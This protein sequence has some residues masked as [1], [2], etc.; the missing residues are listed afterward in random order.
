MT[1]R[2]R[3]ADVFRAGWDEYNR[4]NRVAPHQSKAV[5]HILSCRTARLGGHMYRCDKCAS[6]LPVYNSCQDRHCPT[7][8]T[9][10]K[11]KWLAERRTELIPVRYFHSVFTLPHR[12]NGLVDAN[13]KL[14]IDELFSTVNWTLQSFAADPR[15][16][17]EGQLGFLAVLHTWTQR[18]HE[19]FHIH[20]IIP[21][22][23]WDK[24]RAKWV[25]CRGKWLFRKQSLADAF[26]NRFLVRL[27]LL[28]H[29]GL[30]RFTAAAES[31]ADDQ[32]WKE[33][34]ADLQ[35]TKWVVYPKPAPDGAQTVLNYLG[36]YTHKIAISDYRIVK[37]DNNFVTY[38]WR[39]RADANR[40]KTDTIAVCD[41]IRRFLYHIL[42]KGFQKIRYYGWLS[43]ASK[44][45][46]LP[47][48]RSYLHVHPPPPQ[49]RE[50]FA[51]RIFRLTGKNIHLCPFCNKGQLIKTS[52]IMPCRGPP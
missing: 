21:G 23:V 2:L 35:N 7:C 41:F 31:L 9:S 46:I 20:C 4:S 17:L 26:R 12:L 52:E 29:N 49:P 14:L 8:Q 15:W 13:R 6:Q 25:S 30:L 39:D 44:K 50:S 48:I 1:G 45:T 18:L 19:H 42:P 34:T 10:A 22:G 51:Q 37:I 33:F 27:R 11:E 38:L 5:D 32:R 47:A 40:Q 28:R 36:R 43:A 3:V 24:D 16:R